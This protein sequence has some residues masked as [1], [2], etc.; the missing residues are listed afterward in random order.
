[1]L[2]RNLIVVLLVGLLA[3][4]FPQLVGAQAGRPPEAAPQWGR[5]TEDG[6]GGRQARRG[7][8]MTDR[9]SMLEATA[10]A[11]DMTVAEVVTQL[12]DGQAYSEVATGA[13][14]TAQAIVD[15]MLDVRAEALT[16]AVTDGRFTQ[17]EAAAMLARMATDLLAQTSAP[18]EPRGAGEGHALNGTSP[19]DGAGYRGGN[20][21]G[22]GLQ[23]GSAAGDCINIQ[24]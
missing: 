18:F 10:Q 9:V 4:A 8:W 2:K 20:A 16:Q 12:R 3:L 23:R 22:R 17:E 15:V 11:T 14:T 6:N 13:G 21:H 1:M 7:G 19:R 24:P 5:T